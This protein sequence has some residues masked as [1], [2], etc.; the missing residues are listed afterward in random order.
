[1][2][3]I[4]GCLKRRASEAKAFIAVCRSRTQPSQRGGVEDVA[5]RIDLRETVAVEIGE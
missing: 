4:H 5:A 3:G 2:V 1:M